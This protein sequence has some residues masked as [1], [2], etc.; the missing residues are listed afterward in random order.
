[1]RIKTAI[2]LLFVLGFI[3]ALTA[4]QSSTPSPE[5]TLT[6]EVEKVE[7]EE[8]VETSPPAQPTRPVQ[9]T[10]PAVEQ[11]QV[12][13]NEPYPSP[14][15]FV[16]YNPYPAPVEGEIV[17]WSQVEE[18]IESGEVTEVFQAFSLQVTITMNDG[19]VLVTTEPDRNAIFQLLEQ[20]GIPCYEIRK[21]TE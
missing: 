9:P 17:E 1:M 3:I 12:E 7:T 2:I 11:P 5:P 19:R 6:Q 16:P 4:C 10:Q 15:E 14:I 13:S 18:I 20:C 21:L 8:V